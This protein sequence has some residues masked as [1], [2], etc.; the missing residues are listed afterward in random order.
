MLHCTM[1]PSG[2]QCLCAGMSTGIVHST[3]MKCECEN[4]PAEAGF[5]CA[6]SPGTRAL[7][8]RDE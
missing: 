8:S 5:A 2:D 6:I 3:R 4:S 1:K 7:W